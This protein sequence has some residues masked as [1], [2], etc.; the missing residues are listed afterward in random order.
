MSP[1]PPSD[2]EVML[3][4]SM[5]THASA[6]LDVLYTTADPIRRV[7]S[8]QNLSMDGIS[9]LV[10]QFVH[11]HV[12]GPY[13]LVIDDTDNTFSGATVETK[14]QRTQKTPKR[15]IRGLEAAHICAQHRL[16]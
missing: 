2:G 9:E 3:V 5:P 12:Q 13:T 1:S 10:M 8:C 16:E 15:T 14:I 7:Y 4:V 6:T 11:T